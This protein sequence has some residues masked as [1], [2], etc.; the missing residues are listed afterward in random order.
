MKKQD[1][2]TALYFVCLCLS[3]IILIIGEHGMKN[4]E[5]HLKGKRLLRS[6]SEDEKGKVV[7]FLVA[8]SLLS[9]RAG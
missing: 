1:E 5:S 7:L 9:E 6:M 8:E 2:E 4:S 3:K